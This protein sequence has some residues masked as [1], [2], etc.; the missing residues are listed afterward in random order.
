MGDSAPLDAALFAPG[1]ARDARFV[2][3]ERW[4]ECVNLPGDD[5]RREVEFLHRQMNEEVNGLECAAR[6]LADFPQADWDLQMSIA[7][8]C[9]DEARHVEMFRAL[10]EG[11]GGRVGEYPVLNFQYR[12]ITGHPDLFGRLA[13]Q[14][15]SFEAEGVDAVE[16]EIAAARARGDEGL[17][18][19]FDAQLAD[20]IGH[21][22]FANEAIA[23]AVAKDPA[24]VIRVGRAL[25]QAARAFLQVMGP[26]AIAGVRYAVNR[27]G[28]IEAGFSAE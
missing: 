24:T 18:Q 17:A 12:I 19:L 13:V 28:R 22:R 16:P 9:Y 1:P 6:M 4:G 23:R 2:V 14:N 10:F 20:E 7:R 26:E 25:D 21:V 8:Q 3:R 15:R 27:E 5:P 11:R